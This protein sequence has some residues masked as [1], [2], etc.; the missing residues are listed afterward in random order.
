M[1]S[2]EPIQP[3][4]LNSLKLLFVHGCSFS[5]GNG[6]CQMRAGPPAVAY[7]QTIMLLDKRD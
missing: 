1:G 3:S 6:S 4:P 2:D 5:G 7:S